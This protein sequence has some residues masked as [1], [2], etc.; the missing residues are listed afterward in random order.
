MVTKSEF[1]NIFSKARAEKSIVNPYRPYTHKLYEILGIENAI[2]LLYPSPEL[3]N[4]GYN[5]LLVFPSLPL[6]K[7]KKAVI[8]LNKSMKLFNY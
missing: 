3:G 2:E 1:K 6:T 4:V 7:N 8:V 5:L